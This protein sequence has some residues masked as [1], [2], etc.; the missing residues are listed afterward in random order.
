[1]QS[2]CGLDGELHI[3]YVQTLLEHRVRLRRRSKEET[4]PSPREHGFEFEARVFS[5]G[6]Y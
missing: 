1:M 5:A 4:L 2:A 3:V 6:W